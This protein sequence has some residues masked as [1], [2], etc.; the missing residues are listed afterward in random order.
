LESGLE[1]LLEDFEEI[2]KKMDELR[3]DCD[4]KGITLALN[5]FIAIFDFGF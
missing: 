4:V 1:S 5:K 3:Q 2:S